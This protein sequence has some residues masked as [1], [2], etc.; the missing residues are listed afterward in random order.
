LF[1]G[2]GAVISGLATLTLLFTGI[3]HTTPVP[4]ALRHYVEQAVQPWLQPGEH[5]WIEAMSPLPEGVESATQFDSALS[6]HF[7]SRLVVQ[8]HTPKGLR[9]VPIKIC[10]EKPVW[11]LQTPVATGE[12]ITADNLVLTSRR[13]EQLQEARHWLAEKPGGAIVARMA[14]AKGDL[15]DDR[16]LTEA[17]TIAAQHPITLLV[18]AGN[19]VEIALNGISLQAGRL[20]QSIRVRYPLPGNSK[21]MKEALATVCGPQRARL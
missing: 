4:S 15:L 18:D 20:G 11:V 12:P 10:L 6:Q 1:R 2:C 17:L 21:T 3:G 7:S 16:K 9:G 13:T 8:V 14:L 19:G 5:L